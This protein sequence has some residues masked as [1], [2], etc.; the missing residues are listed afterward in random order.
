MEAR[1]LAALA[2]MQPSAAARRVWLGVGLLVVVAG[3]VL[4]FMMFGGGSKGAPVAAAPAGS[5]GRPGAEPHDHAEEATQYTC[6]MHPQI[7]QDEPGTCPICG[8]NLTPKRSTKKSVKKKRISGVQACEGRPILHYA[9]PMDATYTSPSPGKSPMGMDLVP[10]CEGDGV[11][12]A[13]GISV[14]SRV[15]QNMGIRTAKAARVPL[16]KTIQTVGHVDYD[17]RSMTVITTKFDGWIEDLRVDF[18][19]RTVTK[20]EPLFA[21][22]SPQLVSTQQELIVAYRSWKASNS[23]G[24]LGLLESSRKRLRY[25][26]FSDAQ[27]ATIETSGE[28]TRVLLVEAPMDGVVV[29]KTA[30]QGQFVKAGTALF[31]IA[32]L[33]KVWVYAHFY[34]MDAPFIREGARAVIELPY[35]AGAPMDGTVEYVFPWLDAKTR[36]VKARLVFDNADGRLKPEMYVNVQLVAD[37]G[38][39]AVAIDDSAPIRTGLRSV[40][41]VQSEPGTY[42]PRDVRL[43]RQLDGLVEVTEGIE[44]GDALVIRGQFM[45]DSESRLKEALSK[46]EKVPDDAA[47]KAKDGDATAAK[48]EVTASEAVDALAEKGCAFTCPMESH[49]HICGA[50]AGKC[51]E[52][53]MDMVPLDKAREMFP[54]PDAGKSHEGHTP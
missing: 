38:V 11:E 21:I 23:S 41:F 45:L 20:G 53:G 40:V 51:P 42:M 17:E 32:D 27:I 7:V 47:G 37:L 35:D 52:C 24:A 43:G 26:D 33:S 10:V 39:T 3:V 50:E 4:A 2:T 54:P 30:V 9:A 14:D 1:V 5:D 12:S 48:A 15:R 16:V 29:H 46:Y 25:L 44:V 6:G 8:M 34:E 19:G 13:D 49:L 36:E 22:Y 28:P 18:T 31:R